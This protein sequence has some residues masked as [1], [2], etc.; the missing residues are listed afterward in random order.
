[1][2]ETKEKKSFNQLDSEIEQG[3]S[4]LSES[5]SQSA[6]PASVG[7]TTLRIAFTI[8]LLAIFLAVAIA[9][10]SSVIGIVG[11]VVTLLFC[12]SFH[13][14]F[15]WDR[16][17]VL[18]KGK[19]NRVA[20]PGFVFTVPFFEYVAGTVDMRLRSM[21]FGAEHTLTADLVPVDVDAVL[22]WHVWDAKL[23][24]TELMDYEESVLLASQTSLRDAIGEMG[25]SQLG[26]RRV[27]LDHQIQEVL[28][29]KTN[30]WGITVI[31]VE[32]RDIRIPEELQESMSAEAR[33]ERE[34]NARTLLAEAENEVSDMYVQAARKYNEEEGALQLR[35]MNFVADSV[36]EKGGTIVIP[37]ALSEA[38]ER[39]GGLGKK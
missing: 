18:R 30:E 25:V 14:V 13:V 11:A 17:I 29:E 5:V 28:G 7:P 32:I 27:Q 4:E 34:Y 16:A 10:Q 12:M 31:S 37:S 22:Y 2:K 39:L 3:Q 15:E 35:A 36:K 1:M 19:I 23:A 20:G 9:V 38:F 6:K 26:A 33:A 21:R 8:V 24:C